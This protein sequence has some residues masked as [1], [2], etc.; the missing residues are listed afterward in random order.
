MRIVIGATHNGYHVKSIL[1]EVLRHL[2]HEV[3]DVGVCDSRP[4]DYPDVAAE[5]AGK[6]SRGES[7]RGILLGGAGIGLTIAANKFLGVRAA[8]CH[9]DMT[10]EQSRRHTD[11]NV[12]CLATALLGGRL[13]RRFGWRP[14]LTAAACAAIG[15]THGVKTR[16]TAGWREMT[17]TTELLLR[18]ATS[19]LRSTERSW[20]TRS[21]G[22]SRMTTRRYAQHQRRVHE[23]ALQ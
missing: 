7:D 2:G 16:R 11:S 3:M 8:L 20:V 21:R 19:D 17:P 12:L 14:L 5:V 22:R 6:V 4:V 9:D 10:A 23:R 15:E 18:V 1:V 13:I